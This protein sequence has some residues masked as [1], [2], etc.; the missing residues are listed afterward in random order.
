LNYIKVV[1]LPEKLSVQAFFETHLHWRNKQVQEQ[2]LL[3]FAG[4][5]LDGTSK[6]LFAANGLEPQQIPLKG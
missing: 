2:M 4:A 1:E 6:R 3:V 5:Y